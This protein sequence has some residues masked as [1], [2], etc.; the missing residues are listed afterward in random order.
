MKDRRIM[1]PNFRQVIADHIKDH[2]LAILDERGNKLEILRIAVDE[3]SED[4]DY[5]GELRTLQIVVKDV[6]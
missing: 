1:V 2:Q 5:K 3:T 6:E 4:L